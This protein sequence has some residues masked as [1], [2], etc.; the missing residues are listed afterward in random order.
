MKV[1][2]LGIVM[3]ILMFGLGLWNWI[4][5]F[6]WEFKVIYVVDGEWGEIVFENGEYVDL[7]WV[8]VVNVRGDCLEIKIVSVIFGEGCGRVNCIF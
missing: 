2:L 3:V 5:V 7:Y 6:W 1:V 8:I 4:G